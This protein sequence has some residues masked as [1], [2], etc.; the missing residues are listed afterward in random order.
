MNGTGTHVF[1]NL[2]TKTIIAANHYTVLP[3]PPI[4]ITT[5][6]RWTLSSRTGT[7]IS[8]IMLLM[9]S[10][11]SPPPRRHECQRMPQ[12]WRYYYLMSMDQNSASLI[13]VW[14]HHR[15]VRQWRFGV[16]LHQSPTERTPMS[17]WKKSRS[18]RNSNKNLRMRSVRPHR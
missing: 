3:I 18:Q 2:A 9:I 14:N 12:A 15:R 17:T 1:L 11:K 4:V 10:K 16:R 13:R 8:L 6:N 7:E 5:V